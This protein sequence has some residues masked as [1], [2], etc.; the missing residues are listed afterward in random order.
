MKIEELS[1]E[2]LGQAAACKTAEERLAFL[3][4]NH[5]ELT[6][7]QMSAVSGGI[8]HGHQSGQPQTEDEVCPNSANGHHWIF[9][10]QTRPGKTWGN[11]WPDYLH[12]CEYCQKEEWLWEMLGVNR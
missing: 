5:I 3:K 2:L 1:N 6:L 4:A 11:L 12:A 9:I 8:N 7:E 10:G